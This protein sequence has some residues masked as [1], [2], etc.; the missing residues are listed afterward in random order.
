M[1]LKG[2][3]MISNPQPQVP[4]HRI[5]VQGGTKTSMPH[6]TIWTGHRLFQ[7]LEINFEL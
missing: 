4:I 7:I 5:R 2:A 6:Q 3:A 1:C